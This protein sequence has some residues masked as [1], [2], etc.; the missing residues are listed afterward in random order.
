MFWSTACEKIINLIQKNQWFVT[1]LKLKGTVSTLDNWRTMTSANPSIHAETELLWGR[2]EA[3]WFEHRFN[4]CTLTTNTHMKQHPIIFG[5]I[6]FVTIISPAS[7]SVWPAAL[8]SSGRPGMGNWPAKASTSNLISDTRFWNF[9]PWDSAWMNS[10][11]VALGSRLLC[12]SKVSSIPA[13]GRKASSIM[14][15]HG[16]FFGEWF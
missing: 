2:E 13:G 12:I 1:R 5:S 7:F 10:F 15:H 9:S 11:R 6:M 4:R 14:W 3:S 8:Y 16:V